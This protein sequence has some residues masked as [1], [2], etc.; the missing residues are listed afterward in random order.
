MV[1]RSQIVSHTQTHYYFHK[2]RF[3]LFSEGSRFRFCYLFS[4]T[5]IS[6]NNLSIPN[7]SNFLSVYVCLCFGNILFVI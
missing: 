5:L 1:P 3:S 7:D 4:Y 6:Y 2:N